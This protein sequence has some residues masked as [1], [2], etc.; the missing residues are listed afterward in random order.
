MA[1]IAKRHTSQTPSI[2][3]RPTPAWLAGIRRRLSSLGEAIAEHRRVRRDRKRLSELSDYQL[4]DIGLRRINGR[5][6]VEFVPIEETA[7]HLEWSEPQT[8]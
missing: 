8:G 4:W 6:S 2:L 7:W 1:F 5:Y 3:P